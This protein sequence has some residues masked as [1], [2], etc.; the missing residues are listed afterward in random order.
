MVVTNDDITVVDQDGDANSNDEGG[1]SNNNS[2]SN[3][4]A[5]TNSA[6]TSSGG[7]TSNDNEATLQSVDGSVSGGTSPS[8]VIEDIGDA[9]NDD[10]EGNDDSDNNSVAP[11]NRNSFAGGHFANDESPATTASGAVDSL[12]TM[13]V[14]NLVHDD[15]G[16]DLSSFDQNTGDSDSAPTSNLS[17]NNGADGSSSCGAVAN[18]PAVLL[19]DPTVLMMGISNRAEDNQNHTTSQPG[20]FFVPGIN[21]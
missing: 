15:E 4:G 16:G 10:E 1:G 17:V 12:L 2:A 19:T 14:S 18:D 9:E 20:V 7:S 6:D 5:A 11:V 8:A 3:N 21:Y 13:A